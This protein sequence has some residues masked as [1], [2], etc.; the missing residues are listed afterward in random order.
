VKGFDSLMQAAFLAIVDPRET[1]QPATL[2]PA[3]K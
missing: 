3:P 1:R 2:L